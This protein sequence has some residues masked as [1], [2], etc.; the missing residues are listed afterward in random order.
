[1]APIILP[2]GLALDAA[3]ES[4]RYRASQRSAYQGCLTLADPADSS[5]ERARELGSIAHHYG[6][7]GEQFQS[8]AVEQYRRTAESGH[9]SDTDQSSIQGKALEAHAL[10]LWQNAEPLYK[11]ALTLQEMAVDAEGFAYTLDDYAWLL[12]KMHRNA[13]ADEMAARAKAL[14]E[15]HEPSREVTP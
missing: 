8:R 6:T 15:K 11:R 14:R 1:L 4:K 12:R 13:D 5:G 3:D 2:V 7:L 10:E 9:P